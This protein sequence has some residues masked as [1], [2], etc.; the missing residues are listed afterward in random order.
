MPAFLLTRAMQALHLQHQRTVLACPG[1]KTADGERATLVRLIVAMRGRAAGDAPRSELA[2]GSRT[3][4]GRLG[5]CTCPQ[6]RPPCR[7]GTGRCWSAPP[8]PDLSTLLCTALPGDWRAL[9]VPRLTASCTAY[10]CNAGHCTCGRVLR[11]R[12]ACAATGRRH[13]PGQH[14]RMRSTC[15]HCKRGFGK[16][17]ACSAAGHGGCPTACR[18][19]E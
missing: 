15:N 11:A 8:T 1:M 19:P 7:L 10:A 9:P 13:C 5:A 12:L 18:L 17:M 16:L 2:T 6:W 4:P 14:G 3:G